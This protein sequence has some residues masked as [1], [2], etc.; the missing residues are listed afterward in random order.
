MHDEALI[1]QPLKDTYEKDLHK[2]LTFSTSSETDLKSRAIAIAE[3]AQ[4]LKIFHKNRTIY[5]NHPQKDSDESYRGAR[6][7]K[8][9]NV[10]RT[11]TRGFSTKKELSETNETDE[12]GI[13]IFR[14]Y[15][16]WSLSR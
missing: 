9:G 15:P 8:G 5:W 11:Q 7:A 10:R 6:G 1:S 14:V 16:S 12:T 3:A 13:L 2:M 4:K